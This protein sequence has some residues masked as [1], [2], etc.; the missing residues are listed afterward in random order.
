MGN[1]GLYKNYDPYM[2]AVRKL[3]GYLEKSSDYYSAF[4]NADEFMAY[5]DSV[6]RQNYLNSF[7]SSKA[8]AELDA[9]NGLFDGQ[10]GSVHP[11]EFFAWRRRNR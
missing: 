11:R 6:E 9:L 4:K 2:D 8:Q 5:M 3:G 1:K 7:D 10:Y